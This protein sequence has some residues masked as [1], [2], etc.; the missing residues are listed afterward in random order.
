[1]KR[2]VKLAGLLLLVVVIG[3]FGIWRY[4]QAGDQGRAAEVAADA[5]VS[6]ANAAA[7]WAS[8]RSTHQISVVNLMGTARGAG[9]DGPGRGR[10]AHRGEGGRQPVRAVRRAAP[11]A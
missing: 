10:G 7:K 6:A 1:M 11:R 5:V 4:M 2:F 8:D 3:G 9:I